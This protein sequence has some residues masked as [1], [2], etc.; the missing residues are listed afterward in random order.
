MIKSYTRKINLQ[1]FSKIQSIAVRSKPAH[2]ITDGDESKCLNDHLR[3]KCSSSA[4]NFQ[5]NRLH[6]RPHHLNRVQ[7]RTVRWQIEWNHTRR[8][9][10][11]FYT[12]DVVRP[13]VI[14]DYNVAPIKRRDQYV[15]SDSQGTA[16]WL[17]RPN[18][19][20]MWSDRSSGRKTER[21][22]LA[23]CSAVRCNVPAI[24]QSHSRIC[25]S[26]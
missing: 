9:Q 3:Q 20:C 2:A 21:F 13:H 1:P 10:C 22:E 14:H 8:T 16:P 18:T 24:S 4:A 26:C 17:C 11:L 12:C 23:V 7:I 15:F 19:W 5:Q 6:L 25:E